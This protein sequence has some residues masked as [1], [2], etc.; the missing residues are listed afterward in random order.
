[1]MCVERLGKV[2]SQALNGV[3]FHTDM[4]DLFDFLALKGFYLWQKH[5]LD[6]ELENLNY[7]KHY[8][9][10]KHHMFLKIENANDLPK[11]I[12]SSWL[13]HSALEA[14]AAEVASSVKTALETYWN[15]ECK[16]ADEIKALA[17]GAEGTDKNLICEYHTEVC[18][19]ITHLEQMIM[20]LKATN[21]DS[22]HIQMM[23]KEL[24]DK[25]KNK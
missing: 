22:L 17:E 9:F 20:S 16:V 15:Y 5:Q 14:T 3:M 18:K 19:E 6:E 8:A 13:E 4:T 23:S 2:A 24:Y 7:I 1:M 11:V 21:F 12:P 25:Y 10:T